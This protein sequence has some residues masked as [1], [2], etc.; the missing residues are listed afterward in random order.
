ML[1]ELRTVATGCG[2]IALLA[3][4]LIPLLKLPAQPAR[5]GAPR[6]SIPSTPDP[7]VESIDGAMVLV[8]AGLF[9]LGGASVYAPQPS[10]E[11]E[12]PDFLL[13]RTPVTNADFAGFVLRAQY[14][15]QAE[16]A[17]DRQTWR[18]RYTPDRADHPVVFV[19][20]Y[21]AAAYCSSIR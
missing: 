5:Q 3:A 7:I 21:D 12:L 17:A 19:G 11:I 14:R 2:T 10:V 1:R 18:E 9:F 6:V 20:W 4:S 16:S 13:D 8:P 15:T